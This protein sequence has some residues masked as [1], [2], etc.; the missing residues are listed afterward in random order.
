[1][2][3][4]HNFKFGQ[5]SNPSVSCTPI[6][7]QPTKDYFSS[8]PIPIEAGHKAT[9]LCFGDKFVQSSNG[10]MDYAASLLDLI[11]DKKLVTTNKISD[12]D[13]NWTP[14]T[15][16]GCR[17][18]VGVNQAYFMVGPN[19]DNPVNAPWL[20]STVKGMSVTTQTIDWDE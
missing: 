10:P 16:V 15:P 18:L 3:H 6:T 2:K 20:P 12:Y 9:R 13:Y 19:N 17:D 11:V 7:P 14:A 1:M 8:C 4:G 5:L